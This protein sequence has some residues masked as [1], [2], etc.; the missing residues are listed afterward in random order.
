M[1]AALLLGVAVAV[2][3]AIFVNRGDGGIGG[4]GG[5]GSMMKAMLAILIRWRRRW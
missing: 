4:N 2:A 5:D 3:F 1:L